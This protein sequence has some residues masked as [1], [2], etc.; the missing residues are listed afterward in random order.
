MV[1]TYTLKP[2]AH[3]VHELGE[4]EGASEPYGCVKTRVPQ[5]GGRNEVF[6]PNP[7]RRKRTRTA[8]RKN[9]NGR[10]PKE[11]ADRTKR[12]PKTGRTP[13]T[14]KRNRSPETGAERE[15]FKQKPSVR[16][17]DENGS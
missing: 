7:G 5:R 3:E 8:Q 14:G 6:G 2:E 9:P 15:L 4:H 13:G 12:K 17:P 1:V 11:N 10:T 16:R